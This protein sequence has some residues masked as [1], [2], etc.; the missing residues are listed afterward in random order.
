M[1]PRKRRIVTAAAADTT[2]DQVKR[3]RMAVGET[4]DAETPL[5]VLDW[6]R[7]HPPRRSGF[8]L[9]GELADAGVLVDR[10][11]TVADAHEESI[12][13]RGRDSGLSWGQLADVVDLGSA[14]AAQ[15]LADRHAAA[16]EPGGRRDEKVMQAKRRAERAEAGASRRWVD[17]HQAELR[18]LLIDLADAGDRLV[19][20]EDSPVD[21][22]A[23]AQIA[24][25]AKAPLPRAQRQRVGL[26]I[27]WARKLRLLLAEATTTDASVAA[28]LR[29]AR[30]L[31]ATLP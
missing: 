12:L 19:I 22:E 20:D 30:R 11:R 31:V 6:L 24:A 16:A 8:D 2:I 13:R 7:S 15:A 29:R 25:A 14:Q 28:L 27:K 3:R 26:V 5:E 4:V 1:P 10:I 23:L 21:A 9:A 18:R 17:A